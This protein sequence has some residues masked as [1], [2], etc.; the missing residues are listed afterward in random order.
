MLAD[1]ARMI[2]LAKLSST[3]IASLLAALGRS[4]LWPPAPVPEPYC[5][6]WL[7]ARDCC[8][9]STWSP[10][11]AGPYPAARRQTAS[12]ADLHA[13]RR[14]EV[15]REPEVPRQQRHAHRESRKLQQ[16]RDAPTPSH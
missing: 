9:S 5:D 2:L 12:V 13:C 15:R 10:S 8:S 6:A 16:G 1:A 14:Y 11:V 4:Q 3:V 7:P